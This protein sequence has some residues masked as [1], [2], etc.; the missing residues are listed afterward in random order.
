MYTTHRVSHLLSDDQ[1]FELLSLVAENANS[2]SVHTFKSDAPIYPYLMMRELIK[3][4]F[5]LERLGDNEP[6][7]THL[8]TTV[9]NEV[10]VGYILYH[11]TVGSTKDIAI[12]STIV[13]TSHRGRGLLRNMMEILKNENDSISL[14]CFTDRVPVYTNLGFTAFSS[15]ETQVCMY[16]GYPDDKAIIAV[17]DEY[18]DQMDAVINAKT[19]FKEDNPMTWKNFLGQLNEDNHTECEKAERFIH[20]LS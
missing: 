15:Q 7:A 2:I 1:T 20:S 10:I 17:D 6:R 16:Y 8:I 3:T 5:Y 14:T 19:K 18:V 11:R 13:E 12:I 9:S 4:R